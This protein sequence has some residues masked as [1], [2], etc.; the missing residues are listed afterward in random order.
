MTF[1]WLICFFPWIPFSHDFRYG[2][3]T[4][5]QH[6]RQSQTRKLPQPWEQAIPWLFH[7][8]QLLSMT[9]W[10]I[11]IFQDFSMTAIFSRIF[12]DCGNPDN[13]YGGL[14]SQWNNINVTYCNGALTS[15]PI[16]LLPVGLVNKSM[17]YTEG[18]VEFRAVHQSPAIYSSNHLGLNA[19]LHP[20]RNCVGKMWLL[21]GFSCFFSRWY[22][23]SLDMTCVMPCIVL[24][25]S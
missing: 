2:Y 6:A 21:D 24:V 11:F 23:C 5:S 17:T 18:S 1:P 16:C 3:M 20:L 4:V 12:H 9:F 7:D 10:E 25:T 13:K 14:L 22:F 15:T 8:I 19:L